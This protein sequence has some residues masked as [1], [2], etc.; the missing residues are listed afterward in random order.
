MIKALWPR[1]NRIV[2]LV[3]PLTLHEGRDRP[4]VGIERSLSFDRMKA[5]RLLLTHFSGRYPK[6]PILNA[7]APSESTVEEDSQRAP[8]TFVAFDF[9]HIRFGDFLKGQK[10]LPFL[11]AAFAELKDDEIA[12]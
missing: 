2:Q 8:E 6:L 5:K 4:L 1:K 3:K 11:E 10:Y 7:G 12:V 9:L